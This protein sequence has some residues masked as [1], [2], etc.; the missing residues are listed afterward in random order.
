VILTPGY[1][2]RGLI[3]FRNEVFRQYVNMVP[4]LFPGVDARVD[5]EVP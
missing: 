3:R 5:Q 1:Q 2:D 4:S